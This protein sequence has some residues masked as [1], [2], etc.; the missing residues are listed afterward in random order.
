MKTP[1]L[2]SLLLACF[3]SR[4]LSQQTHIENVIVE[5]PEESLNLPVKHFDRLK[6]SKSIYMIQKLTAEA[7]LCRENGRLQKSC[8]VQTRDQIYTGT[9]KGI[10]LWDG[11]ARIDITTE[12]S[13]LPE[14]NITALAL[15]KDQNLLIGTSASGMVKGYGQ[16]IK[17]FKLKPIKTHNFSIVSITPDDQGFVWVLYRTGCFECFENDIPYAFFTPV[18]K[19]VTRGIPMEN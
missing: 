11:S 13:K 19:T 15:D 1:I 7:R 10:R 2:L 17:P 8:F 16:S 4:S 18:P 9:P 12:N 14:N 5:W 3:G 6:T